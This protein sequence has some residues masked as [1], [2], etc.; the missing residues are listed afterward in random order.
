[1]NLIFLLAY[2][3]WGLSELLLNRLLH[4]KTTDQPNKDER[5][6]SVIWI[7][8]VVSIVAAV[9]IALHDYL[10]IGDPAVI[11]YLGLFLLLAGI[12]LRLIV[13]RSLGAFFTV[14]VTIRQEHALKTDGFY[15]YLRHPSYA[16]SLLSF[17][18]FGLSLNNWLSLLLI[19]VAVMIVFIRRIEVEEK[20]LV[21][22]FGAAY[23][24]Y[25]KRTNRLI[26]FIY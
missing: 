5:S 9:Y 11:A 26:P 6:L 2:V 4:S 14:D 1:M 7:T 21:G 12:V 10:P 23:M 15:R 13:V 20:V 25:Q 19:F 16:A 17:I 24:D 22:H 3:I 8:V 18:G